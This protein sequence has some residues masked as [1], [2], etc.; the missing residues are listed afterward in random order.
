M[1]RLITE[2]DRQF[3]KK[4]AK[5]LSDVKLAEVTGLSTSTIQRAR[6][7]DGV[8]R[9][10]SREER[11]P[12]NQIKEFIE[13]NK[14]SMSD[15][16]MANELGYSFLGFQ[17]LRLKLG[18]SRHCHTRSRPNHELETLIKDNWRTKTDKE[19]ALMVSPTFPAY[20]VR[21]RRKR[22]GIKK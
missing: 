7:L 13:K 21:H 20:N 15:T 22:L 10:K 1:R 4:N 6:L 12:H 8:L 9:A 19:I 5:L 3:I 14:S 16:E 17:K 11:V 18:F 2:E